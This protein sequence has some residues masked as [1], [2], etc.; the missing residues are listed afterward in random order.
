MVLIAIAALPLHPCV[1]KG[2]ENPNHLHDKLVASLVQSY[3]DTLQ[4]VFADVKS[5]T[6]EPR[7]TALS[8]AAT[9]PQPAPCSCKASS[10]GSVP[11]STPTSADLPRQETSQ[12]HA[13]SQ[14]SNEAEPKSAKTVSSTPS[15]HGPSSPTSESV[16]ANPRNADSAHEQSSQ[17]AY[18]SWGTA[19]AELHNQDDDKAASSG[20]IAGYS[21]QLPPGVKQDACIMMWIGADDVPALTHL[22]LTFN[23]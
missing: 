11:Y 10:K 13:A 2:Q 6:M 23:K 16:A 19:G 17:G 20:Q 18:A 12:A 15:E 7:A 5:Q 9:Q 8:E 1:A 14:T 3:T 4:V 21:W 22:H